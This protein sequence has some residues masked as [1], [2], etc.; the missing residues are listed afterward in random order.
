MGTVKAHVRALL[1]KL[2]VHS[3]VQ[4]VIVARQRGLVG[5][6]ETPR[7][8]LHQVGAAPPAVAALDEPRLLIA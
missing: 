1:E 3:R 2:G 4:A 5:R 7:P 8:A 6:P